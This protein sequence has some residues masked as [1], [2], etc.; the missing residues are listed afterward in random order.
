MSL[1]FPIAD[2]LFHPP[3]GSMRRELIAGTFSGGGD[4]QRATGAVAPF[5]NVNAYG[6]RVSFFTIPAGFGYVVGSPNVY[7][8]R[9]VQLTAVYEDAVGNADTLESVDI[10]YERFWLWAE[11]GPLRIHYEVLPGCVVA[12]QWMIVKFP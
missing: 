12:F 2:A 11:P 3:Y 4:L 1:V 6:L 7:Y 9:I 5:N 10:H 8:D